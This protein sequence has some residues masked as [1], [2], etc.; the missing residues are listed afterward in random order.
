MNRT[1]HVNKELIADQ[2]STSYL[3]AAFEKVVSQIKQTEHLKLIWWCLATCILCGTLA[4]YLSVSS[5]FTFGILMVLGSGGCVWFWLLSRALFRDSMVLYSKIVWIV[6]VVIAVEAVEALMT[7]ASSN[8]AMNEFSRVFNNL[9]SLVCIAAIVYVWNETLNGFSKIRSKPERRFRIAFL[10]VF[11]FIV[12]VAVL[13][14]MGA[15]AETFASEWNNGLMTFCALTGMIGS[16]LAVA[17][18]LRT[19]LSQSSRSQLIETHALAKSA[20]EL[21]SVSDANLIADKVIRAIESEALLTQPN[22]KVSNLADYIDEQ[23][24]KV[25]RCITNTLNYRNFN[26][27]VNKY[28]IDRALNM[29]KNPENSHLNIATIAFDCGYNSLGPFN[30]AFKQYT[31]KTPSQYRLVNIDKI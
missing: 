27:M 2:E 28:R 23:E 26:H 3:K 10:S 25:T 18:R 31:D 21:S 20:D 19:L 17:Y 5:G 30:R 22:L 15:K 12:A 16:R 8:G 11:S 24:Y 1:N 14:V 7:Q 29:L 4:R 13:W 9:T 6:P